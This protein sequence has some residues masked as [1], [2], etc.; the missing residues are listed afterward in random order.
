MV[1]FVMMVGEGL[2]LFGQRDALGVAQPPM[3]R[4]R[5]RQGAVDTDFPRE[6]TRVSGG[7]GV[8]F[9]QRPRQASSSMAWGTVNIRGQL[10]KPKWFAEESDLN[11]RVGRIF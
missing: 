8:R 11:V 5:F 6:Q 2:A 7:E 10:D 4:V 1:S 3:R 9:G